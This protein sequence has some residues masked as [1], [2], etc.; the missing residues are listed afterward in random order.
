MVLQIADIYSG[1][2]EESLSF[3][4]EIIEDETILKA[5]VGL[6]QDMLELY[7]WE[8]ALAKPEIFS[9]MKGRLDMGGI[10]GERGT[11]VSLKK[12][13]DMVCGVELIKNKKLSIS[14]WADAPLTNEQ[15]AYAARDAWAS[16]AVMHELQLRDP[17]TYSIE[18][19][20]QQVLEEEID[21]QELDAR[22]SARREAELEV[23][24]IMGVGTK[25]GKRSRRSLH[26]IELAR[27]K[28]LEQRMKELAPPKPFL[29]DL[30]P[31][32]LT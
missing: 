13:A 19:L 21:I 28:A 7:R 18:R 3:L 24:D 11:T 31:L 6:D 2:R 22:A 29:F 25:E 15:I 27:V 1:A 16:A 30:N 4:S 9:S 20:L 14:E 5:G 32:G 26:R 17:T 8:P 23:Q 10:G 12:L